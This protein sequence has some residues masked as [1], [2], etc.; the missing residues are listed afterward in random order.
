MRY[1]EFVPGSVV[2][3]I[4]SLVVSRDEGKPGVV[5]RYDDKRAWQVE[6]W[7]QEA[8]DQRMQEAIAIGDF[9]GEFPILWSTGVVEWV[10]GGRLCF[11]SRIGEYRK[12]VSVAA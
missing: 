7:T 11:Y 10:S 6:G 5:L 12:P 9:L 4:Y 8:M 2:G 3:A 1:S